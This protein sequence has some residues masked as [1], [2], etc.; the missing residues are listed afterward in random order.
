MR[1]L[2]FTKSGKHFILGKEGIRTPISC[3]ETPAFTARCVYRFR[4]LVLALLLL[5]TAVSFPFVGTVGFTPTRLTAAAPIRIDICCMIPLLKPVAYAAVSII[6]PHP[7]IL[8]RL[9]K[10]VR[11]VNELLCKYTKFFS[12]CK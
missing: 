3:K 12:N 10:P 8:S 11:L 7:D 4:H 1:N 2:V 6:P 5:Q 9:V